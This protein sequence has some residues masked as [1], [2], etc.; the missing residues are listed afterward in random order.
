MEPVFGSIWL[1]LKYNCSLS[2]VVVF[3][4]THPTSLDNSAQRSVST[5]QIWGQP[6]GKHTNSGVAHEIPSYPS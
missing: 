1:L 2:F 3:D 6:W 4:W 5:S